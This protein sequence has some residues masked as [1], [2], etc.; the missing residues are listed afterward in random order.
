MRVCDDGEE[1]CHGIADSHAIQIKATF[2]I[3][4]DDKK[5][6]TVDKIVQEIVSQCS[7]TFDSQRGSQGTP[8]MS[9]PGYIAPNAFSKDKRQ[10]LDVW[11]ELAVFGQCIYPHQTGVREVC[12]EAAEEAATE[13]MEGL[14]LDIAA[15]KTKGQYVIRLQPVDDEFHKLGGQ[16]ADCG[17]CHG[18]WIE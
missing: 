1:D 10:A 2:G 6:A 12:L 14:L 8:W 13:I 4:T 11:A 16:G 7:N 9:G 3:S 17:G 18:G 15:A 5:G